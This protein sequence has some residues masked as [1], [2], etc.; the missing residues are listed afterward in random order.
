ML[1]EKLRHIPSNEKLL[2]EIQKYDLG[3]AFS[4]RVLELVK[5][6]NSVVNL[7]NYGGW[8][9]R[10]LLYERQ[11]QDVWYE[12]IIDRTGAPFTRQRYQKLTPASLERV[13]RPA[14]YLA[15][16]EVLDEVKGREVL[17]EHG[18]YRSIPTPAHIQYLR[19]GFAYGSASAINVVAFEP[20]ENIS[21]YKEPELIVFP[22]DL[23]AEFLRHIPTVDIVVETPKFDR[24]SPYGFWQDMY[25]D[26]DISADKTTIVSSSDSWVQRLNTAP[27]G[28][29]VQL[30]NTWSRYKFN[31]EHESIFLNTSIWDQMSGGSEQ[32]VDLA[33]R[34]LL[35]A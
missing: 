28:V 25:Y 18:S 4:Q 27:G 13:I 3:D 19:D 21:V 29:E 11:R 30:E 26:L 33:T 8:V 20:R 23:R 9:T 7:K 2:S 16:S 15:W 34:Y 14:K 6:A 5:R 31:T 10:L 24:E 35:Q 17:F 32:F 22:S 1:S 12:T